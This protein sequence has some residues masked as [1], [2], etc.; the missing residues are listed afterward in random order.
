M[1]LQ[2]MILIIQ[3]ANLLI[4]VILFCIKPFRYWFLGI[5]ER[6]KKD[7]EAE[8]VER[9]AIKCLLRSEITR[10]YYARRH[11][12]R[13]HQDEYSNLAMLYSAYKKLGG[14]SFVDRIWDEVQE[15]EIIH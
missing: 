3:G 14:N 6:A 7:A 4:P 12:R 11:T 9:E 8:A 15:W 10:I 1:T 13:L 5:K 2:E